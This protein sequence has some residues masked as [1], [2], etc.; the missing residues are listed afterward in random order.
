MFF[1]E[2]KEKRPAAG[3]QLV[4]EDVDGLVDV[5]VQRLFDVLDLAGAEQVADRQTLEE[6]MRELG[7]R[8]AARIAGLANASLQEDVEVDLALRTPRGRRAK[9]LLSRRASVALQHAFAQASD[10]VERHH[11]VGILHTVSDGPDLLRMEVEGA[12]GDLRLAVQP[13]VGA[14]LGPLL[15]KR[16]AADVEVTVKWHAASGRETRSYRL[17]HAEAARPA[18][19][20]LP[21]PDGAA[22]Q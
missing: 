6:S 9:G 11:L 21:P 13:Q 12:R 16:I 10:R 19:I 20:E 7:V 4:N 14:G 17:L 8:A 15:S 2:A 1:L 18:Q 22:S 3:A 5:A